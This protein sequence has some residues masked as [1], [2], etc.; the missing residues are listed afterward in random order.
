MRILFLTILSPQYQGDY[1]ELTIF[2]GLRKILGENCIDV[3]RKDVCY[4]D[5]S[6]Y[7]KPSLHGRGFTLLS[8]PIQD[9]DESLR[10]HYKDIDYDAVLVGHGHLY[11]EDHTTRLDGV[12][13]KS[14]WILDGHDL[15]GRA[16]RL[17][18][19]NGKV[20][21]GAQFRNSFKRELVEDLPPEFNVYPTGFGVPLEVIRPVN[22][23]RKTQLFQRTAPSRSL[24]GQDPELGTRLHHVF[25]SEEEYYD[26]MARSWF[27][28]TC[29]KGGWDALRHYEI[30]AAGSLVLFRDFDSKP[31]RCSPQGLPALSYSTPEQLKSLVESLLQDGKPTSFY[32][33]QLEMQRRW[34]F[35]HGTTTARASM[36]YQRILQHL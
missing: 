4:H 27:G 2:N 14:I 20:V 3:P 24:F 22:L 21:I 13:S 5:F 36:V 31:V 34:L 30:I 28:L 35:D 15:F 17:I 9:I 33:S 6:K 26:D 1:M 16:P 8:Y 19:H 18:E 32:L 25:D 29:I 7:P 23:A 11:G 10:N 12:R